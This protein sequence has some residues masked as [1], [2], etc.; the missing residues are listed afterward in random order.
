MAA[1]SLRI[2]ALVTDGFGGH[3]GI[4][5][6]NRD[7]MSS[8]AACDWVSEVIVLAR[9]T[10]TSPSALP[11]GVRQ[12]GPVK[13]KARYLFAALRTARAH[14]PIDVVFCGHLF[15]AP[16]AGLVSKLSR[17]QLWVQ[18]HGFEA[19]EELSGVYR[20]SIEDAALITSVSRYSRRQLLKWVSIDPARVKVLP[21]TVDP[22]FQS[23]PKP[24]Y[25]LDRHRLHGRKVLMTVSRLTKWDRYKGHE[26]VLR[27][28]PSIL[29]ERP[30]T[31]YLIVGDGDDRSRLEGLAAEL[32]VGE[33]VRFA[34][35]VSPEELPDYYRVGDVFVMP[36]TGE[37]FGIVFLEAMASGVQVIGG[38]RDGSRDA[39]CDGALGTLVDPEN[40]EELAYAVQLA[41]DDAAL[42]GDR[43]HR[44]KPHLFKGHLDAM[45]QFISNQPR[46]SRAG[47]RKTQK[48]M[49]SISSPLARAHPN[50]HA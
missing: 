19:W 37:G 40:G 43:T 35:S 17:A 36:S 45:H 22:S 27:I 25:L 8:I 18:V 26:R 1:S 46:G 49:E 34:G 4:A 44:F 16:L 10:A 42:T 21:N 38:G 50:S 47:R 41:L 39:L 7:L 24:T 32:E 28:L 9:G 48:M 30:D 23:G 3:G 12:L 6:Y 15:M 5:Q 13:G 31:V 11:S 14:S 20:Q 2:L 29:A 33:K